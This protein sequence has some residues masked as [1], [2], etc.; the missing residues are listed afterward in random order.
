MDEYLNLNHMELIPEHEIDKN[1][2]ECFYFPHH[3]VIKESSTTTKLRVVFDGSM[4][5]LSGVSLNDKLMAGPTI[6]EELTSIMIRWRLH[7]IV[8]IADI[9]KMYRQIAINKQD[10]DFQR[11][12]WRKSSDAPIQDFRLKTVTYGTKSA[13]Y[14]AIKTLQQ[15]ALD[16]KYKYQHGSEIILIK[17]FLCR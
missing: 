8:F 2:A 13:P 9:E 17:R 10:T 1:P 15:L 5:T 3:A 12:V 14:L 16:Y 11:V 6:Q 7:K 4:K